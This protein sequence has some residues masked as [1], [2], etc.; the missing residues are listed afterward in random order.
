MYFILFFLQ[1]IFIIALAV[2]GEVV[3]N[4]RQ[5]YGWAGLHVFTI[6]VNKLLF[7][8]NE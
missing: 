1:D 4:G 5:W 8:L 7:V 6:M 2:S 3:A